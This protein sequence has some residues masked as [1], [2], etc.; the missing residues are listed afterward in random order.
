ME[1]PFEVFEKKWQNIWKE[2][3]VFNAENSV[4]GKENYYVLSMFPYPSGVLHMGH[5]SNYSIGDAISRYKLMQGYNVLQPIGYDSFGMPAENYAIQHNSHPRIA[6]E[7]NIKIMQGQFESMGF[8]FDWERL[9]AT[10]RPDYHH[11]G[12]WLFKKLYEKG[13]VYK[14]KSFVNWCDKC[15]TVL[16]NEQ[17]VDGKCW[18]DGSVVRQKELEQ[19]YFK[20]TDY[21]EE[22]LDF[23]KL[24]DWPERVVAMQK[25]WIGRSVGT[26][27]NFTDE[28]SN[29][30]LPVFT[31]RPDTIFGVTFM[32][33]P[34]E[35]EYI[36][37][38]LKNENNKEL[39]DFCEKVINADK[40]ERGS[41][42]QA[43]EGFFTG[44]YCINPVNGDKVQIWVTNYVLMDYGTGAVMAVPTHDQRDFDFAKKYNIPMKIVIQNPEKELVLDEMTA[45]YTDPGIL[46][47]SGDFTGKES[48]KSKKEISNWIAETNKGE[49]TVTY[50]LRDWGV[51]RQ[52]YWG[53][54]IPVVY[55]EKC[56]TVLVPD[57][58][59]PVLLPENVQVGKTTQNPL[60]SVEDWVNCK[61]PQC[62]GPARRETD[63]MDTF[64]DSSWYFARYTDS[65]NSEEPFNPEIAAKWLPVDQY[66]GG[67]EHACMHLIYARFFHKFMRDIGLVN[68]DE[69]FARLLTQGM[70]CNQG[71]KMSKSKGNG[72]DPQPYVDRYG[73]DAI[74]TFM[75]FAS[76]P[77]KDV[78]W[79]DEGVVGAFRFL[80]RVYRQAHDYV[81]IIK[82]YNVA[83]DETLEISKEMKELRRSTHAMIKKWIEDLQN[84]LQFNTA[85]AAVMEHLNKVSAIKNPE[86]LSEN[87]RI[88]FAEANVA[89]FRLIYVFAPHVSEEV[90]SMIGQ[91]SLVHE[92]GV[93]EFNP[94]YLVRDEIT[95]V[96]QVNGKIRGK[97]EVANDTPEDQ[98]KEL[99]LNLDNVKK[100]TDGKNIFKVIVIKKKLINI[101]AK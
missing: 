43:K 77:E 25:N 68:C 48:A 93:P 44:R 67:I 58:Q 101:V 86:S 96:V 91:T 46:V 5:V 15:Q 59:L 38:I 73:A 41:D 50:R 31:T 85:I 76:P 36:R 72:V 51:S 56:G 2:K 7:D 45:A 65:Q 74:R 80:N 40:K 53:N 66:I 28:K 16:A 75:L 27:I 63:T 37:N 54:P 18:R 13:L 49:Q 95:Y 98:V 30:K 94:K 32:A 29:E 33:L 82:K 69:P 88:I 61:C 42:D 3:R 47:N 84:R 92:A 81:D 22:L 62:G 100:F 14:K 55:C 71:S 6:T 39:N 9:L 21:A 26:I 87:D 52:R 97:L 8:G 99:A 79:N 34:P 12:Q 17:V 90:W 60:L 57:E 83:Y 1:Y 70:V 10:S 78:D 89:M 23:S 64:V 4:E 19:W 35:H 24:V 20:I 11:W